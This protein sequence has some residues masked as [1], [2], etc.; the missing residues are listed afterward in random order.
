MPWNM[1]DLLAN[2]SK[3]RRSTI[4]ERPMSP[5]HAKHEKR[6]GYEDWLVLAGKMVGDHAPMDPVERE[7]W[8]HFFIPKLR[9]AKF[10]SRI[11]NTD[12]GHGEA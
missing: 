6:L 12:G 1:P 10:G 8:R 11:Y 7:R 4:L 9:T 5:A 2:A 3:A